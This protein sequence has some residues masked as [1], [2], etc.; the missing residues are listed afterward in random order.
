[1]RVQKLEKI[2]LEDNSLEILKVLESHL[3]Y[4]I[5]DNVGRVI[6]AN[7][8]Y[9]KLVGK[10]LGTIIGYGN[11]ILKS[12]LSTDKIYKELWK[13]I[14][15]GNSWKGVLFHQSPGS[16]HLW[17]ETA[18]Y[19]MQS[20]KGS[21]KY[22]SIYENITD[23]YELQ[24]ITDTREA[25]AKFALRKMSQITLSV[26]KRAKILRATD[27]ELNKDYDDVVG[28]YIYD[29]I[30]KDYHD[31]IRSKLKEV[32]DYKTR[33]DFQFASCP[34]KS[35]KE[36]Y[37]SD[38]EPILNKS[39]EVS[40]VNIT[41]EIKTKDITLLRQLRDIETKYKAVLK[42][43]E[44]G[45]IVVTDDKGVIKEW[46]KGAQLAFGYTESEVVGKSLTKLISKKHL[47]EGLNELLKIKDATGGHN[48]GETT[49]L[50][51][52][53][54]NGAEFPVELA[55]YE[56]YC[57]SDR[58]F[59]AIMLDVTSRKTLEKRLLQ[60]TKDL[61]LFLYRSAHDLKAPITS[62]EGLIEL[63]KDENI[64]QNTLALLE[65]LETTL[66]QGKLLFDNLAFASSIR[67]KINEHNVINFELEINKI[68]KVLSGLDG[69]ESIDFEIN[70]EQTKRFLSN[71]E[72]LCSIFQNLIQNAIIY[73][74]PATKGF[75]PKIK[76]EVKQMSSQVQI[77]VSDNGTGI[78]NTNKDKVFDICYRASNEGKQGTGLGLYIVK[79]IVEDLNG[80]ITVDSQ[81]N[82]GTT[83]K[84]I[85]PN[86]TK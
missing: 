41:T 84:I 1:M 67:Q 17:L 61:E 29:F 69:F 60:K 51:G 78:S 50:I 3:A 42:S 13:A 24:N 77:S 76:V 8:N 22:L 80:T 53:K 72:L 9:C 19:P 74:K 48:R 23:Y 33:G 86:Q 20:K 49:E 25:D 82:I 14:K 43:C 7:E 39:G 12:H 38:I 36:L 16:K 54:K 10:P 44:F 5:T 56:W 57:G 83:F 35:N 26:N 58:Y 32:F 11:D 64:D 37:I 6:Y 27:N 21:Q 18:V 71:R 55:I 30:E 62:A 73:S 28:E 31:A 70:I 47:Q 46:N 4:S 34:S 59:S 66:N 40:Y 85:L 68:L 2:K 81:P 63:L 45:M 52:L 15:K 75:L 65:M 79:C